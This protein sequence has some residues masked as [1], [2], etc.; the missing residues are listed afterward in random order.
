MMHV[1][2]RANI[3]G[4]RL[5]RTRGI[6][7]SDHAVALAAKP[8]HHS[9][10]SLKHIK[11]FTDECNFI[12]QKLLWIIFSDQPLQNRVN[13]SNTSYIFIIYAYFQHYYAFSFT[14]YLSVTTV[15]VFE[16]NSQN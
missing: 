13:N 14:Y 4:R 10:V 12:W 11:T 2:L 5:G 1:A 9:I 15:L 7:K 6:E 16:S 3:N 8:S